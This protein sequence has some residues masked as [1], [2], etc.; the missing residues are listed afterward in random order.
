MKYISNTIYHTGNKP[1]FISLSAIALAIGSLLFSLPHFVT[2]RY[3]V[4]T[5]NFSDAEIMLH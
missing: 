5:V 2:G 1:L 3:Q 4:S